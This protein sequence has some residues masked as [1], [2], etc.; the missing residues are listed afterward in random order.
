MLTYRRHG[1]KGRLTMLTKYKQ[2]LENAD[3]SHIP[4]QELL[5]NVVADLEWLRRHL[6]LC[7]E[8]AAQEANTR[9]EAYAATGRAYDS[10]AHHEMRG[11][12]FGYRRALASLGR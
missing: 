6:E 10:A 7:A 11:R 8:T 12:A 4:A 5:E 2:M 1:E 3:L 9:A